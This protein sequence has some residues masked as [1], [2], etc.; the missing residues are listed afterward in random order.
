MQMHFCTR[1]F[2]FPISRI[3]RYTHLRHIKL[4]ICPLL[5][6]HLRWWLSVHP[7]KRTTSMPTFNSNL[8]YWASRCLLWF[9][10]TLLCL[11]LV[12]LFHISP[13]FGFQ[14]TQTS[15]MKQVYYAVFASHRLCLIYCGHQFLC[16]LN[17]SFCSSVN[18]PK[19][20]FCKYFPLVSLL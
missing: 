9:D 4:S 12:L 18:H 5:L 1:T 17:L 7:V 10:S 2:I 11:M 6:F 14:L 15:F 16:F 8:F 19:I 13:Q 20:V 3:M